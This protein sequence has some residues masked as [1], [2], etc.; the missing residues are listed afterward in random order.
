M[1]GILVQRSE[2]FFDGLA[3]SQRYQQE[4][5]LSAVLFS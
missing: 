5:S 3:S 4:S 1:A 2:T